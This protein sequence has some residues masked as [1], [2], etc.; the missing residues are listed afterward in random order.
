MQWGQVAL[1]HHKYAWP[2]CGGWRLGGGK[3]WRVGGLLGLEAGVAPDDLD[4]VAEHKD[5]GHAADEV[6]D[7]GKSREGTCGDTADGCHGVAVLVMSD[8]AGDCAARK[9]GGDQRDADNAA[10]EGSGKRQASDGDN[11][12]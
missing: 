12:Q 7:E 5:K 8:H 10:Q 4:N 2:F 1:Q 11:Q 9:S 3:A 6:A